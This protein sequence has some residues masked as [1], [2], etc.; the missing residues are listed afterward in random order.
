MRHYERGRE[1]A[2]AAV[3]QI[4]RCKPIPS[5]DEYVCSECGWGVGKRV[6]DP[7]TRRC[8]GREYEEASAAE[9]ARRRAEERPRSQ[10][11]GGPGTELTRILRRLGINYTPGCSCPQ[12]AVQMDAWGPDGCEENI[13]TIVG[14]MREEAQK[15]T[16]QQIIATAGG[17]ATVE[18]PVLFSAFVAKR[19]VKLAIRR[20]R[21]IEGP[22]E[23]RHT[24]G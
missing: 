21:R 1:S 24:S 15:R 9:K 2:G 23:S 12:H 6:R 8:R 17:T 22:P 20:A 10:P 4:V 5:G 7:F 18:M 13:D 16:R 19:F 3:N 11:R 14:W